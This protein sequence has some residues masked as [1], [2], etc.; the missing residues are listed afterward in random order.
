M[1]KSLWEKAAGYISRYLEIDSSLLDEDSKNTL[2]KA[3]AELSQVVK[4]MLATALERMDY[5]DILR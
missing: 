1:R 2:G 3:Q 5:D 4:S